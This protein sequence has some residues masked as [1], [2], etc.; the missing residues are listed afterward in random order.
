[1]STCII[2]TFC[3]FTQRS[4]CLVNIVCCELTVC[5]GIFKNKTYMTKQNRRLILVNYVESMKK[6]YDKQIEHATN[7]MFRRKRT[8]K[9]LAK[10]LIQSHTCVSSQYILK[11]NLKLFTVTDQDGRAIQGASIES[12]IP[13]LTQRVVFTLDF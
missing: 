6:S 10:R 5:H 4:T 11:E 1:M 2:K 9:Q 12:P 8:N 13:Y 7:I 3:V